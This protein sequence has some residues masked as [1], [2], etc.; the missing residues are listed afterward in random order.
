M[1]ACGI[2][3]P[4]YWAM[5]LLDEAPSRAQRME[6]RRR[7]KRYIEA[8]LKT[9]QTYLRIAQT[10]H[11]VPDRENAECAC[12]KAAEAI[13]KTRHL[14]NDGGLTLPEIQVVSDEIAQLEWTLSQIRETGSAW[15][16]HQR[17]HAWKSATRSNR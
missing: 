14:L 4:F 11:S 13:Q 15:V 3:R 6:E 16:Q 5:K 12:N 7:R 2:Y 8:E 9:I 1:S 17:G 10:W